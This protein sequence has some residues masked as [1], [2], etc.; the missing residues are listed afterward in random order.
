MIKRKV[1]NYRVTLTE[2]NEV[3]VSSTS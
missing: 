1:G 3:I 2:N